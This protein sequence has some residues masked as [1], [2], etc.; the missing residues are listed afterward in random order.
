MIR[1]KMSEGWTL[2]YRIE[3]WKEGR[4]KGDIN[5]RATS[6]RQKAKIKEKGKRT[7]ETGGKTI[8]ETTSNKNSS[9]QQQN[10]STNINT[11]R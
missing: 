10:I 6:Q 1:K 3:I 4:I 5:E 11:Q 9:Q 8:T 2:T 7:K